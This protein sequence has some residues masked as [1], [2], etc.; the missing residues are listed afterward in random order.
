MNNNSKQNTNNIEFQ[1]NFINDAGVSIGGKLIITS[2]LLIFKAHK[3]NLG[4]LSDKYFSI[5]NVVGYKKGFF[6]FFKIYFSDGNI[7]T[8]NVWKKQEIINAIEER[9]KHLNM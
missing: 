8:L 4:D 5:K 9:K 6:T 7:V 3:F 2:E 1:A